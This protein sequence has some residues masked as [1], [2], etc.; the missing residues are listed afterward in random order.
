MREHGVQL[1]VSLGVQH[2]P[3]R[4]PNGFP[5][6][7]GARDLL[8]LHGDPRRGGSAITRYHVEIRSDGLVEELRQVDP[9]GARPCTADLDGLVGIGDVLQGP[10]PGPAHEHTCR[11]ALDRS[12]DPGQFL[13]LDLNLRIAESLK[14]HVAAIPDAEHGAVALCPL[15]DVVGGYQAAG[16]GHILHYE[17]G[18]SRNVFAHVAHDLARVRVVPTAR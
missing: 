11:D 9:G 15:L 12:A 5:A 6:P 14:R 4:N 13:R 18:V 1:V 8:G 7:A 3:G 16:T 2:R 10:H 17:T